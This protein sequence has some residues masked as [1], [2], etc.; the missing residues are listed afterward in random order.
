M[1]IRSLHPWKLD[2]ARARALQEALAGRVSEHEPPGFSPRL[3]AGADMSHRRGSP[4]LYAAVVVLRLPDFAVVEQAGA[5]RRATFPY[6]PGFLSFREGPVV[7]AAFRKLRTQPD[8]VLFD[9][10][11]RAHPRRCGLACHLGLWLDRPS[12]GCAKSC[13]C[14]QYGQVGPQG[15][16]R[17]E[18]RLEGRRI[19][20]LLRTREGSK[21]LVVSVGH[22]I[23]LAAAEALVLACTKCG[24]RLP[25]PLRLVHLLV[26]DLRRKREE[27]P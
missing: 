9:G 3:V 25:E 16:A 4:W 7:L 19:G 13:L 8:A 22:R 2:L 20:T 1:R 10:Q 26:N 17:S 18:L 11:G 27:I 5:R 14:G 23:S 6:I 24:H 21:P 15:G 12:L